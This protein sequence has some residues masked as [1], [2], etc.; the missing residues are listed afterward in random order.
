MK[1]LFKSGVGGLLLVLIFCGTTFANIGGSDSFGYSWSDSKGSTP[2]VSFNW[3]DIASPENDTGIT[4]YGYGRFDIGFDFEFYGNTYPLVVVYPNGLISFSFHEGYFPNSRIPDMDYPNNFVA[5]FWGNP[6]LS[7]KSH[8]YYKTLGSAPNRLSVIQYNNVH[9]GENFSSSLDF[10]VLLHEDGSVIFQY[11]NLVGNYSDGT[12]ATVGIENAK[13]NIG[14]QYSYNEPKLRPGLAIKFT[15]NLNVRSI[16]PADSAEQVALNSR[17]FIEFDRPLDQKT[18]TESVFSVSGSSSGDIPFN[19]NYIPS[20]DAIE[21]IPGV[22]FV[23]GEAISINVLTDLKSELGTGLSS[24]Y[25]WSFVAGSAV[26]DQAPKEVVGLAARDVTDA[27][28]S[29]VL[30]SWDKNIEDDIAFYEIFRGSA[31]FTDA[32]AAEKIGNTYANEYVDQ[33]SDLN[34]QYYYAVVAVDRSGNYHPYVRPTG[35]VNVTDPPPVAPS[36][37]SASADKDGIHIAWA[38]NS[39]GDLAGYKVYYGKIPG[40][41][42]GSVALGNVTSYQLTEVQ[43]CT[44]YYIAVS[45]LDLS[46]HESALSSE[47]RIRSSLTEAPSV[48][49]GLTAS[50]ASG[51]YGNSITITWEPNEECE[52][53]AYRVYRSTSSGGPFEEIARSIGFDSVVYF[54]YK[55]VSEETYYY[56]VAAE[57]IYGRI[58]DPSEVVSQQAPLDTTSPNKIYSIYLYQAANGIRVRWYGN[59]SSTRDLAGYKIYFRSYSENSFESIA[60]PSQGGSYNETNITSLEDCTQYVFSVTAYDFS[61]NES[62]LYR[63]RYISN[64][65]SGP[66]AD[67]SGLRAT[68]SDGKIRLDWDQNT[69]CDFYEYKIYRS[70]NTE[71]PFGWIGNATYSTYFEDKKIENGITYYY[72]VFA[73]DKSGTYSVGSSVVSAA[74]I[75]TIPPNRPSLPYASLNS[76]G[77]YIYWYGNNYYTEDLAGYKIYYGTASGEYSKVVT[78]NTSNGY[79]PGYTITELVDCTEYY[80]AVS[81]ID[82]SGNETVLSGERNIK[83]GNEGSPS[84]PSGVAVSSENGFIRVTW[85]ANPECDLASYEI[86]RN[87]SIDGYF[88]RIGDTS[89]LSTNFFQDRTLIHGTTYFYKV[90]ARDKGG[91]YS[92]YSEIVSATAID[93]IPP[94]RPSPPGFN[95]YANKIRLSWYGNNSN[96]YDLAGYRIYYGTS[97]GN[98]TDFITQSSSY[99]G[100]VSRDFYDLQDCTR[101]YFAISA[102]DLSGN[103]SILSYEGSVTTKSAGAPSAPTGL[104]TTVENGLITLQWE[105]NTE[106]DFRKYLIYRS[107]SLDG[108]YSYLGYSFGAASTSFQDRNVDNGTTYY[109]KV[110]AEDDTSQTSVYSEVVSAAALDTI[111]PA[112]PRNLNASAS[113]NGI[114]LSWYGNNY[115]TQDLAGYKIHYGTSSGEYEGEAF[116]AT[117][118]LY[119]NYY[120]LY[121]LSPC[122]DYYISVSAV[123]RS[124]N[125]SGLSGEV[126]FNSGVPGAPSTPVG[127]EASSEDG[128]ITLTWAAN[129][130]CDQ[131]D[132]YLYRSTDNY[133]FSYLGTVSEASYADT[134]VADGT[135]YYYR[136][137]A[138]DLSDTVSPYSETVSAVGIDTS[139][140]AAPTNVSSYPYRSWYSDYIRVVW[141]RN[142]EPDVYQYKVYFGTKRGEYPSTQTTYDTYLNVGGLQGCTPYYFAVTAIDLSGHESQL[143]TE[144]SSVYNGSSYLQAPKGLS[145]SSAE[146]VINLNWDAN[147]ECDIRGYK[148]YRS[149]SSAS[150]YN[151]MGTVDGKTTYQDNRVADGVRYYYVVRAYNFNGV[152][153]SNSAEAYADG[154]D[155]QPP[156]PPAYLSVSSGGD[157]IDANWSSSSSPDVKEFHVYHHVQGGQYGEP[158]VTSNTYLRISSLQNCQTYSVVV[159]AVDFSGLESGNSPERSIYTYLAG[160]PSPPVGVSGTVDRDTASLNWQPNSECDF[161]EY[162]IYRSVLPGA[163]Y[164]RVGT[165][166]GTFFKDT[167][168]QES[169]TFY[170]VVRAVDEE[171]NESVVSQEVALA[172]PDYTPPVF[173]V[174]TYEPRASEATQAI[175]GAKEPGCV[176]KVNGESISDA[177]DVNETW[178]YKVTLVEGITTKLVFTAADAA[179]NTTVRSITLLFDASP[180]EALVAGALQADGDG[181]GSEIELTWPSYVEPEDL[182]Y[183]RVYLSTSPIN[184]LAGLDPVA[185][186]DRGTKVYTAA[187]LLEGT[188][189][190]FVVVP[191]DFA[192]NWMNTIYPASG[193]AT[194]TLPPA[195]VTGFAAHAAYDATGGNT[196][197][198]RWTASVDA[199]A[200]GDLVDQL[201]YIDSGSGYPDTG[202]S[203]GPEAVS[204]TLN[205]LADATLYRFRLRTKDASNP[206][207]AGVTAEAVTRLSNPTGLT[208]TPGKNQI[209]LRWQPVASSYV[210]EYRVYRVQYDQ[211]LANVAGLT[212]V[213][214]LTATTWA[215]SG[216]TNGLP[217]QY[218]V[219]VANTSGVEDTAVAG[220]QAIPRQDAIGPVV[221]GPFIVDPQKGDIAVTQNQVIAQP[222]VFKASAADAESV[223]GSIE[224]LIDGTPLGCDTVAASAVSGCYWNIVDAVDGNHS[225][226]VTARDEHTNLTEVERT[227]AVSLA[228]PA[229]PIIEQPSAGAILDTGAVTVSGTKP[230]YSTV[231][232]K[233]NGVVAGESPAEDLAGET[234]SIPSANLVEGDN[235][236]AVKAIHRG[237]SSPYGS[238]RRVVVD[239]GPPP[240]PVNLSGKALAGGT[241]QF[242]WQAGA[243]E[244]PT[245]FNL[246]VSTAPFTSTTEDGVGKVNASPLPYLFHEII[247]VDET[248]FYY[249]VIA[250]DGAGNES[251]LSNAVQ[252]AA[253]GSAPELQSVTFAYNDGPEQASPTVGTGSVTVAVS[254][255]EAL[256]AAPFFSIEPP[257]GSPIIVPLT[258][259]DDL[260]YTGSFQVAETTPHGQTVYKFSAKDLI[261]NRGSGQGTGPL[262]DVQGPRMIVTAPLTLA[263]ITDQAIGV[264]LTFDEPPVGVPSVR[265]VDVNG[266]EAAVTGLTPETDGVSWSG[267]VALSDLDDG[268]A[269]FELVEARDAFGNLGTTV[270]AGERILLYTDVPPAPAVPEGLT[271]TALKGGEIALAW[272]VVSDA[273]GYRVYRKGANDADFT[274]LQEVDAAS[275]TDLPAQDDLYSYTVTSLGLLQ[276]ESA[277]SAEA[278]AA[279]DR[280]APGAP[281]GL[282]LTIDGSGVKATW[283][284]VQVAGS[285]EVEVPET[286]RLYRAAT[287]IT[288]ISG[289]VPVA[290]SAT[291]EALDTAPD[292]GKRHYVVTAL[293]AL[294]N[295]SAPSADVEIDFPV[296]PVA[297]LVL[298]QFEGGKPTIA[299]SST[300]SGLQGYYIY[301]NGRRINDSPSPATSFQDGF[302]SGG[303]A[304]YWVTAV[305][306]YGNESPT[307]EVSLRPLQIGLPEGTTL[308]RGLLET[309]PV[310]L[311]SAEPLEVSAVKIKVGSAPW[312]TLTQAL[313]LAE[314]GSDPGTYAGELSKVAGTPLDAPAEVAV[315]CTAVLQPAP[316][317]RLEI[318]RTSTVPVAAS[319]AAL[320]VFNEPLVRGTQGQVRLK[321]NNL[322]SATMEFLTSE[323]GKATSQVTVYLRDQDGN[324]LAEGH[325]NQRTGSQVVNSIGFASAR[326]E[327]GATFLSEPITFPVPATAPDKVMIEA[328]IANTYYHYSWPDQVVAPGLRQSVQASIAEVP[329]NASASVDKAVYH[330]GE[331]VLISGSAL[332][333]ATGEPVPQAPVKI[334]VSVRGFDRFYDVVTDE[335]G[336]FSHTFTPGPYE[337]GTYS[338]WAVHPDL[339]DRTVQAGFDI[340]GLQVSPNVY[341]LSLPRGRSFDVPVTL[342]NLGN[343]EIGGLAF[344]TSSSDGLTATVINGGDDKLTGGESQK[345]ALRVASAADA[346]QTGFASLVVNTAGGL[347]QRV[348]VNVNMVTLIPVI[349][350]SPSYIDTGLMRGTQKVQSFTLKNSGREVLKNARLEGPSTSWMSLTVDRNLGDVAVGASVP[351]GILFRPGESVPAGVYDDQVTI[352]SDNHIPYRVNVQATVTSDAIGSAYFDVQSELWDETSGGYEKIAGA[353]LT[354]QHQS[355]LEL[356]YNLTTGPGGTVRLDDIPEGRYSYNVSAPGHLPYSG[357]FVVEAGL[358]SDVA[359]ALEANMVDV[360]FSVVPVTIEDRYEIQVTQTF[361]TNVP[362]PV[363]IV[364][365]ASIMLPDMQPGEV[366]NGEFTVTNYG[367]IAVYDVMPEFPSSF[368]NYDME[369][370]TEA[371]PDRIEAMQTIRVPYRITKRVLTASAR[372]NIY[373]EVSG[374]GGGDCY[375]TNYI[376]IKGKCII[377]PN[378][379]TERVVEKIV[380]YLISGRSSYPCGGGSG[381]GGGGFGFTYGSGGGGSG[382]TQGSGGGLPGLATPIETTNPCDCVEEG[383]C[384]GLIDGEY[385]KCENGDPV[386]VKL[387]SA[388]A[389]VEGKSQLIAPF[390][391]GNTVNVNFS[392][393]VESQN[394][395]PEYRWDL[396][397]GK[398]Y[399]QSS[400]AQPYNAPCKSEVNLE[401]SCKECS[402]P[403][404]HSSVAVQLVNLK[405]LSGGGVT[406][407]DGSEEDI[408]IILVK[409]GTTLTF[410]VEKNPSDATWPQGY[411]IWG[412]SSGA[413]ASGITENITV[414]FDTVS[415]N[416]SDYKTVEVECG[417]KL[418]INVLVYDYVVGIHSSLTG[419]RSDFV[420]GHA[421]ITVINLNTNLAASYGLWPDTHPSIINTPENNGDGSDVR[422]GREPLVGQANRYY[423]LFPDQ[424]DVLANWVMQVQHW[425]Y[426]YTCAA[427]ASDTIRTVIGVDVDADDILGFETPRELIESINRLESSDPTSVNHPSHD[428]QVSGSF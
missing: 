105:Q 376:A 403:S 177:T 30:L 182:A 279:S 43:S 96:T 350:V 65:S 124:G 168:L 122:T 209:F 383:T 259:V 311:S 205:D 32:S 265:L 47:F 181:S 218:A 89:D 385:K 422:V 239:T 147:T 199:G 404:K 64:G 380:R 134:W 395:D 1:K 344:E 71:G 121:N 90:R 315:V 358:T 191:V 317:V 193:T 175:A 138:R 151:L 335:T 320:E 271:A 295:E 4:N 410:S 9:V 363:L 285:T 183:Y 3:I 109:Y 136:I 27:S 334:G 67:V 420:D 202:L 187:G 78:Y 406:I 387:T 362:T 281:G 51:Y 252:I 172:I 386:T 371:I 194:D 14:L 17:V 186:V 213:H 351:V 114:Y 233:V 347:S 339:E 393:S 66:P 108:N 312:S 200:D 419:D 139:I 274:L 243:G 231:T 88:Y 59:N 340:I 156:Q 341:N 74:G 297:E 116:Y 388:V 165:T 22:Q 327:P 224:L 255:S 346:P 173:T 322:G 267:A 264:N 146:S 401:V 53:A 364:E 92:T 221:S 24:N 208:A 269:A 245:G 131:K 46:G 145:A 314:S 166:R 355:L 397:G 289:L 133:Y 50:T 115:A 29:K 330:M 148:I 141:N 179:G 305:D 60:F 99:G 129:T 378:T 152:T 86:Y 5:P 197:T 159:R 149:E 408:P 117:S 111:P 417:N 381:G 296:A 164:Q 161:R 276:S 127:L 372:S 190:Y 230:A 176:V 261:G 396:G 33:I 328:V 49:I 256:S 301:R 240:A 294:G 198:L 37:V 214:K 235:I 11:K 83:S 26:D 80:I 258:K 292:S 272:S 290:K 249:A 329:Y 132:Y 273:K 130:E 300:E 309:V 34:Q 91:L 232:L 106:C 70:N 394:C 143:S 377:C 35:P 379:P 126:A 423:A 370:M 367:L 7:E 375:V 326:I 398:V 2:S 242:G 236:L 227:V 325:L 356:R 63:T 185:T 48:P 260:H 229:V 178:S 222:V 204:Y 361:Q 366:F 95:I 257:S 135:T 55:L 19:T 58:G 44:D 155:S 69:D 299:W 283:D 280:T 160:A 20:L 389:K 308:H 192:G 421:W 373:E 85:A 84:A 303:S 52:I 226:K 154:L 12:W 112:T 6:Y 263:Q 241:V 38:P 157:F 118:R 170:Y 318:T 110:R 293:D 174:D 113:G 81:A 307:R 123:D 266:A 337:V 286:Y 104:S 195:E 18:I 407:E 211:S 100:N 10:E 103:E 391:P 244:V 87:T 251:G 413:G 270:A 101:Y 382:G 302:Y 360:E 345:V 36:G 137:R 304:T 287:A 94:S 343:A 217:Y 333:T 62:P 8:I 184:D 306:A 42:E 140:P 207:S 323:N 97:S 331:Q 424:R 384:L 56:R 277:A 400:F 412:G 75:D 77:I 196:A 291:L 405:S 41:N 102:V 120:N 150:G 201:L 212:P 223:M 215:D 332:D 237:G 336:A 234:F 203:V 93:S 262:I 427:W 368:E 61:G 128:M 73:S 188:T 210:Q 284:G 416:S 313:T 125:E 349:S 254:V 402:P 415:S 365:P 225:I 144:T 411:P 39:E 348:D 399:N 354:V 253:D 409:K 342:R 310:A 162:R 288:D 76:Q 278:S 359:V 180:P 98:Y 238:E 79:R 426:T 119:W 414:D 31:T 216:L 352:Y 153:S 189:Y 28:G 268:E 219:T 82:L 357:S 298:T 392:S 250:Q 72:K 353:S 23:P 246:Y 428:V 167:E 68:S 321:V 369:V 390:G 169:T 40:S 228:A 248:P 171:N 45:A 158:Q 374:F 425:S 220:V 282:A 142:Q 13:G 16:Y 338:V 107:T 206:E 54:D 57:D 247:P 316:G 324:L 275:L 319:G 163:G 418:K 21:I 25:V 15:R